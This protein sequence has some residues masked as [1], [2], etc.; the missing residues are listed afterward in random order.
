MTL[1][2]QTNGNV[3]KTYEYDSFENDGVNVCD[4]SGHKKLYIVK[5]HVIYQ[6]KKAKRIFEYIIN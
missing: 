6:K 2:M 3:I 4:L 5:W 1:C